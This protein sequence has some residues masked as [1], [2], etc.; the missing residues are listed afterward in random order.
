MAPISRRIVLAAAGALVLGGCE[1]RFE[2]ARLTVSTGIRGAVYDQLGTVLAAA[3][4]KNLDFTANV[5][6]SA[7]SGQNLD[8]LLGAQADV[9]FSAADAAAARAATTGGGHLQALTRMH[10]D[11]VQ[12][13]VPA[14]SPVKR[15]AEL[16]GMRVSVGQADSGVRLIADRLLAGVG[17]SGGTDVDRRPLAIDD[18]ADALYRGQ[19]DAFFWSG[20]LPTAQVTELARRIP[21]RVVDLSDLLSQVSKQYQEYGAATLPGSAYQ[22]ADSVT[23]LLVPNLLLATDRMSDAVAKALTQGV[24]DAQPAL[25]AANRAARSIDSRSGIETSPV[26]LHPGALAYYRAAH[27]VS[28]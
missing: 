18:A 14:S 20:G 10:D 11:Y 16:R 8:R 1:Q 21:I 23:T 3:W 17:L 12:V 25:A 6:P 22:L 9:G 28:G 19:I 7:G 13:V 24:F 26:S 5:L 2:G 4:A 27:Y 15:L